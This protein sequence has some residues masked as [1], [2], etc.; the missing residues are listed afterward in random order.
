MLLDMVL[1]AA[2]LNDM[3]KHLKFSFL[4]TMK[5]VMNN[6]IFCFFLVMFG[7]QLGT[8]NTV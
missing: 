7:I 8:A 4:M 3:V 1:G 6:E 2:N 5:M